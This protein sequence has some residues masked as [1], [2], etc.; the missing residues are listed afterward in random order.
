MT[1]LEPHSSASPRLRAGDGHSIPLRIWHPPPEIAVSAV[2]QVLH[3]LGEHVGRYERFATACN[4][5]GYAVVGHDHRGH[6]VAGESPEPG[7]FADRSGWNKVVQ[8]A[9][10]VQRFASGHWPQL[11]LVLFG[12]SM[13]SY[14]A[15]SLVAR[16][17]GATRALILSASTFGSRRQLLLGRVLARLVMLRSGG[18]SKSALLNRLGLGNFNRRFAPART[19]FDWL[20]RDASEVDK[21]VADSLCGFPMSNGLWADLLGGLLEVTSLRRLRRIPATLPILISGGEDDPVGG[22][23]G[24]RR[25]AEAYVRTGHTKVTLKLYPQGRHEMLNETN[26]DEFTR[27]VL[28]WIGDAM[29]A[30]DRP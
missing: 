21:Y 10:M 25:L 4:D 17:P 7:H 19:E 29:S 14:I 11:P 28:R 27:D 1:E 23:S 6:G 12:H 22:R 30:G 15:Q 18:R 5:N 20:S 16:Q 24:Q 3:G 26:R 2:V 9:L 8:D 13:G